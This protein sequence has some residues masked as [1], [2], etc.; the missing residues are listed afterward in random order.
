MCGRKK[1]IFEWVIFI[2]GFLSFGLNAQLKNKNMRGKIPK[3]SYLIQ[4]VITKQKSD[5]C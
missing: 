2:V 4:L 1:V 3:P 5:W